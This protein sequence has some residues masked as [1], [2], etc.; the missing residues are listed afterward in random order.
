MSYASSS[1]MSNSSV[2][3]FKLPYIIGVY[4]ASLIFSQKVMQYFV[5]SALVRSFPR[6]FVLVTASTSIT[7]GYSTL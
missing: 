6:A 2:K 4:P 1:L 5:R 3:V 7:T